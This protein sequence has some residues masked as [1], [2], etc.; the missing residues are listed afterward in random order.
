MITTKAYI[1]KLPEE[2]SNIFRVNV[3]LMTDNV[4]EEAEFDA[5]LST[6]PGIYNGLKE[7]DCVIV[8]FEDDKYNTA[9]ILGKLFTE[10]PDKEQAYGLFNQLNVTGSAVLPEDTKIGG[11]T[12][13]DFY[14][15]FQGIENKEGGI[16]SDLLKKYV[17]WKFTDEA[18]EKDEDPTLDDLRLYANTMRI[19][20]L[21]W[22][23]PKVPKDEDG[24]Y[25]DDQGNIILPKSNDMNI[26]AQTR[27]INMVQFTAEGDQP[28]DETL[29]DPRKYADKIKIMTGEEYDIERTSVD[30][31]VFNH[32]L[33]FLSSLP[34]SDEV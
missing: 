17:S 4:S 2:G 5:I 21:H 18:L 9:I 27:R 25:V 28:E 10:I 13:Q 14:N 7:G 6:S 33:Y 12:P 29:P 32:T 8:D 24:E 34:A 30:S 15:M 19:D 26:Y 3:P 16:N 20:H 31:E 11:Y 1:T 23:A 22:K